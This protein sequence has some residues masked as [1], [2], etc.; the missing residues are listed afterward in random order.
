MI[1]DN[2]RQD[3]SLELTLNRALSGLSTSDS[4]TKAREQYCR[5]T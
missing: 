5:K 4:D 3:E 1:Y 2:L